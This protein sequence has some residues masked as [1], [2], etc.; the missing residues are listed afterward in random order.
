MS[1][2]ALPAD[3]VFTIA[4]ILDPC[5]AVS[6]AR[7]CKSVHAGLEGTNYLARHRDLVSNYEKV[8]FDESSDFKHH[9]ASLVHAIND[10]PR[11]A[12]YVR[13]L[14][15]TYG[16]K[17]WD[18]KIIRQ[19]DIATEKW[20]QD[21]EEENEPDGWPQFLLEVNPTESDAFGLLFWMLPNVK[22]VRIALS[23]WH[24]DDDPHCAWTY[25]KYEVRPW[26]LETIKI[27]I[28]DE[29][30]KLETIKTKVPDEAWNERYWWHFRPLLRHPSLRKFRISNAKT[31]WANGQQFNNDHEYG[32]PKLSPSVEEI[33]F[34]NSCMP[35]PLLKDAIKLA[36]NLRA[37]HYEHEDTDCGEWIYENFS[38][39]LPDRLEALSLTAKDIYG[40]PWKPLQ[41][42]YL[43]LH[44]CPQLIRRLHSLKDL[45][46]EAAFLVLDSR[47]IHQT[48]HPDYDQYWDPSGEDLTPETHE[49]LK[50]DD[51]G[52]KLIPE[53]GLERYI[54]NVHK[55]VDILPPSIE[56]LKIRIAP[57]TISLAKRLFEDFVKSYPRCLPNL[58]RIIVTDF[59][60]DLQATVQEI[61]DAVNTDCSRQPDPG[62]WYDDCERVR[63]LMSEK[64]IKPMVPFTRMKLEEF[65]NG[66]I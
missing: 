30:G 39:F 3:I 38:S 36:P 20:A 56:R 50:V 11:I 26:K 66:D 58:Q 48:F 31:T 19:C 35:I 27:K 21:H 41:T 23:S 65:A 17:A 51:D 61:Y 14:K 24:D 33:R 16:D 44:I 13:N 64:E 2:S 9:P 8:V 22:K 29:A 18:P 5:D 34:L 45:C 28:P 6:F 37:F 32:P 1:L 63:Y 57:L 62:N 49:W 55:L 15:W 60:R 53:D 52:D 54:A 4:Y 7:T 59:P 10:N 47:Q 46:I 12:Y 25:G 40:L 43:D 42:P